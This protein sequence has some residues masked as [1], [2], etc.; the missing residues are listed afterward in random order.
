MWVSVILWIHKAMLMWMACEATWGNA[1]VRGQHAI[2]SHIL[3]HGPAAAG[4][5]IDVVGPCYTTEGHVNVHCLCCHG[6]LWWGGWSV[7]WQ[8]VVLM[9]GSTQSV[10]PPETTLI[11]VAVLISKTVWVSAVSANT[12]NSVEIHDRAPADGRGQGNWVQTD[13]WERTEKASVTAHALP[14][15]KKEWPRQKAIEEKVLKNS[16]KDNEV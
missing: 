14:D 10:L 5:H 8:R 11:S 6:G 13:S 1:D 4:N 2:N 12:R 9:S 7:L 16:N 3:A 15:P